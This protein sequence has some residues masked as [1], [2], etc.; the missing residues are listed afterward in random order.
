MERLPFPDLAVAP[1]LRPPGRELDHPRVLDEEIHVA[2]KG[3]EVPLEDGGFSAASNMSVPKFT[4]LDPGY[5]A[6]TPSNTVVFPT[7]GMPTT[8]T[9]SGTR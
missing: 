1:Q 9:R 2:A 7:P 4:S 3:L 6:T 5:P 8:T